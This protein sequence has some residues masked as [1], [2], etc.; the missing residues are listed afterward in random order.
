MQT[1]KGAAVK[2]TYQ[3]RFGH[4]SLKSALSSLLA[5]ALKTRGFAEQRILTDWQLIVGELLA[6]YSTPKKLQ[7]PGSERKDGVLHVEVYDSGLAM[8]LQHLEPQLLEKIATY[9]GYRAVGK[10]KI[11]HR[12]RPAG[13]IPAPALKVAPPLDVTPSEKEV[14]TQ[15]V[16]GIE[17]PALAEILLS[18][19]GRVI[20]RAKQRK[21]QLTKKGN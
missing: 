5:P 11:L 2:P 14:L 10:L 8:Q 7:F 15:Q 9:F 19:G 12:I 13:F 6:R 3:R 16:A 4:D 17:D 1:P 18:L 21:Q 20:D